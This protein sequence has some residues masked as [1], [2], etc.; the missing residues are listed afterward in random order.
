MVETFLTAPDMFTHYVALDPSTWWNKGALIDSAPTL[1]KAFHAKP[2]SL[3]LAISNIF[4]MGE[5]VTRLDKLLHQNPPKGL[6]WSYL[7]RLDLDH[8][9]IYAALEGPA[10]A[11]ALR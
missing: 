9:T 4:E 8:S 10:L 11:S 6:T 2:R 1:L 7:Q 5:S 3:Y